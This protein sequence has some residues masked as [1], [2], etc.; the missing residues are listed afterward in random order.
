MTDKA[1]AKVEEIQ[2]PWWEVLFQKDY[3][4]DLAETVI[5]RLREI[6]DDVNGRTTGYLR[7]PQCLRDR[8]LSIPQLKMLLRAEIQSI[9]SLHQSLRDSLKKDMPSDDPLVLE[10]QVKEVIACPCRYSGINKTSQRCH[11]CSVFK[12]IDRKSVV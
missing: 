3:L 8:F 7:H 5:P 6:L 10:T 11:S 1:V 2:H 4:L 12:L 9:H